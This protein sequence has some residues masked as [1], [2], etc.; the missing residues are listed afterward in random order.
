M[1]ISINSVFYKSKFLFI[2]L[3]GLLV[4]I[5]TQ[6]VAGQ[7]S[8]SSL[9]ISPYTGYV[10]GGKIRVSTGDLSI[11]DSQNYGIFV[12]FPVRRQVSAGF[13]YSYQP[14]HMNFWHL[15]DGTTEKLFDMDVHYFMLGGQYDYPTASNVIWFGSFGIGASVFS[16]KNTLE[17]SDEWRF[18]VNLGG[19]A[20]IFFSN[21]IGIRLQAMMNIPIQWGGTGF[22]FGSGG[23]GISVGGGSTFVQ[24]NFLAGLMFRL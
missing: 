23:S 12:E 19:G 18:A 16:P 6:P 8:K 22:Y 10:A 13:Y 21:V 9:Q 14:T 1:E 24:G 7:K 11:N 5:S 4:L 2:I 17:Y 3:A 20:K 15:R